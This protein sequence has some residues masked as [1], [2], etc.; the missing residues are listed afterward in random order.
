MLHL[1][2]SISYYLLAVFFCGFC[3]S[4]IHG[5][6]IEPEGHTRVEDFSTPLPVTYLAQLR[7]VEASPVVVG[8]VDKNLRRSIPSLE[9]SR[10]TTSS[11][12]PQAFSWG[13]VHGRS[14]LSRPLNQHLPQYCGSCWAH[15]ALSSLADR[16]RIAKYRQGYYHSD[17]DEVDLSVQ[18]LLNCGSEIAGSCR[19]GSS[20]GAYEFIRQTGYVPYDTCQPYL[21]CSQ[22]SNEGFCSHVDTT[23]TPLNTCKTCSSSMPG[24]PSCVAIDTFPNATVREYGIYRYDAFAIMAEIY[25]RG[26]VKASVTAEFLTN[27]TGGIIYDSPEYHT[28]YHNHGVSIVGWGYEQDKDIQYWIVRNSWGEYW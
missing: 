28:D 26:P 6:E 27:Y 23:C 21:A 4:N 2:I 15:A 8:P 3:V 10:T 9:A 22:D 18:F 19:G 11:L 16:I 14:F 25:L 24:K 5:I 17:D 7:V 1:C 13:N 12:V 20:T